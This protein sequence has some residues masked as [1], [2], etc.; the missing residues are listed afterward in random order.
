MK[1]PAL[2]ETERLLN[3]AEAKNPGGWADHT[4]YVALAAR[5]IAE[6]HP[7]L[8]A[9]AAYILGL[10][11][12]IG[13][14][15]GVTGHRHILDGY[16]FLARL[17]YSDAA[18]ICLT[19]SYPLQDIEAGTGGWDGSS[20]ELAFVEAFLNGLEYDDYDRLLQLCDALAW[21]SGFVMIEKRLIDVALRYGIDIMTVEKWRAFLGL[22]TYFEGAI[23]RSIYSVL[24]GVVENTFGFTPPVAPTTD[25]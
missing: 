9:E 6:L 10:L 14:Q 20:D 18:R 3:E 15:E 19:H 16:T 7:D 23:G 17:G 8:D 22:Q 11:H 1:I 12:D 21:P 13:R 24:P 2:A 4:R 5:N 25:A